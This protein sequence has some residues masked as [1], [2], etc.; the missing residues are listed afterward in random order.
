MIPKPGVGYGV[1]ISHFLIGGLFHITLQMQLILE[2]NNS[3]KNFRAGSN[4]VGRHYMTPG[5][6][7]SSCDGNIPQKDSDLIFWSFFSSL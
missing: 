7:N 6:D 2:T 5:L 4:G 1:V 3:R